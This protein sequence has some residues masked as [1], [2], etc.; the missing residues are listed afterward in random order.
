MEFRILGPVEIRAADRPLDIGHPLQRA[1]LAVLLLD[2]NRVVLTEQLIDRVWGSNPPATVRNVLY[3]YLARLRAALAAGADD[4]V[5]LSRR[6]GGYVLQAG[7]QQLDLNRFRTLT[8]EAAEEG[9]DARAETLLHD[10]LGLWHGLPLAGLG[11]PWL[12]AIRDSLE[13]ERAAAALDLTDIRLRRGKHG[14]LVAELAAHAAA[15]PA[16]ERLVGQLMLAL[17]RSSRQ[18]EALRW[19]ERT[20]QH[21]A[22]EVGADPSPQL[23]A[24]HR[25]ILRADPALAAPPAVSTRETD[26]LP[27]QLPAD[28]P[29]FTGRAAEL[30]VLDRL[31]LAGTAGDTGRDP[32]A[33]AV[34]SAVSG[35]AGVG[36]T[37]LAVHWAHR[38]AA[39]FPDGQLHVNL[40]GYDPAQPVTAGDALARFLRALGVSAQDIPAD[41]DERA[42]RY[43]SLLAGKR[44]LILLDNASSIDQVRPLLPGDAGCAVLV[45]SRD[46][47]AGLVA[48]DG[49]RRIDLDLLPLADAVTL[50]RSLIGGRAAADPHATA[51]LAED[52]A[53]LPLALRIAAE[54]A[55]GQPAA[56]LADLAAQ[57][58]D[59]RHR[60]DLL[61]AGGDP[62]TAV[63]AVF[64]WSYDRLDS[65][66]ACAFRLAG[67][68]P[69]LD[70]DAYAIAALTSATLGDVDRELDA[71]AGAHLIEPTIPGRHGLHDLLRAYA[72]ELAEQVDGERQSRAALTRLFDH[73]LA[74]AASAMDAAYP[75]ERHRRPRIPASPGPAPAVVN[76]DAAMAWLDAERANLVAMVTHAAGSGWPAHAT[77]ASGLLFRNLQD[78]GHIA[79]EAT[80]H[81]AARRAARDTG[82]LAAESSAL[83]ALGLV[84]WRQGRYEEAADDHTQA[85]ALS[86]K[87]DDRTGQARALYNLGIV[88]MDQGGYAPAARHFRRALALHR[89]TGDRT[90]QAAALNALG[91]L[92]EHQGRY[93][94][95]ATYCRQSLA[96]SRETGHKT[97]EAVASVNLGRVVRRLGRC[98]QAAEHHQQALALFRQIGN[99]RGEAVALG[100]LGVVDYLLGRY[101]QAAEWHTQALDI[102]R[103]I[104]DPEAEADSRNGLGEALLATGQAAAALAQHTTALD[105]A[106]QIGHKQQ[107][108]RAH[109]GLGRCY[110]VSNQLSLAR[111]HWRQALALY[112]ELGAPEA[113]DVRGRLADDGRP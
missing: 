52:C 18:A 16:D 17:Y 57:L 53:R 89:E 96:L 88:E 73:Y 24:L 55:A 100:N 66:T 12:D 113:D 6:P 19:F 29:A 33:A 76:S 101:R 92:A 32:E 41:Q 59:L 90:G 87:A 77:R 68:H 103:A 2:L 81:T 25:Q 106:S 51:T 14:P 94:Q 67:L 112:T 108:A 11:G 27:R 91:N 85:L 28:V 79:E 47:L 86:R 63:R 48:R 49:A 70:F 65:G 83:T 97:A 74:T 98:Q 45:T 107:Q 95:A 7:P 75:A 44:V 37:A 39:H 40:R 64:S 54:L 13:L 46:S 3:S 72:R 60:L 104:K 9:D 22:D 21:L 71:L 102:C 110:Q 31:L 84:K 50:L 56:P 80:I 5:T 58:G 15:T 62:H 43:R 26:P 109:D 30:A 78:R 4:R 36:K 8:A 38:A 42:A 111:E 93:R 34:I 35:T 20:R 105:L 1:V 23:Q 61:D 99:R 69:G 82:D 10:A